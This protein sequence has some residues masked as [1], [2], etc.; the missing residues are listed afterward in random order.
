MKVDV[1]KASISDMADLRDKITAVRAAGGK[2]NIDTKD[3]TA[4]I[5]ALDEEV[6]Q[7]DSDL[8][9]LTA[10]ATGMGKKLENE[11]KITGVKGVTP[12]VVKGLLD[13]LKDASP[14]VRKMGGDMMQDLVDTIATYDDEMAEHGTTFMD[15]FRR[16]LEKAAQL[17]PVT[18]EK[19]Q[20]VINAIIA[21]YPELKP[22]AD[23][24]GAILTAGVNS[25]DPSGVLARL[26]TIAAAAVATAAQ[27]R[28][29]FGVAANAT[30]SKP[31]AGAG[32]GGMAP[33]AAELAK[34]TSAWNELNKTAI[35]GWSQ[36]TEVALGRFGDMEQGIASLG[37]NMGSQILSWRSMRAALDE[38]NIALKN[39]DDQI[40]ASEKAIK[41]LEEQQTAYSEALQKS[42]DELQKLSTMKI[43]GEGAASDKSFAL[44]QQSASLQLQILKA[45]D[46]H[47]YALVGKL[48]KQK[49]V[50]DR[51]KEEAD[52]QASITYDPQKRELEK[53]LDPLHGQEM[54]FDAIKTR[55]ID[56]TTNIIP[57]QQKQYDD[58]TGTIETQKL[59]LEG[60]KTA[61][62]EAAVKVAFYSEQVELM[63]KN[64]LSRYD[65]M[66]A[67]AKE[68][69]SVTGTGAGGG[70]TASMAGG[71]KPVTAPSAGTTTVVSPIYLDGKKITEVVTRIIG[72]NASA[73]SRS[74]GVY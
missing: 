70:V 31:G 54:S 44:Q 28:S 74:G 30:P 27:L 19:V 13:Q 32:A 24:L 66:I 20:E 15:E 6:A 73:Y 65:E 8:A 67:K 46:A 38:A 60:I 42:K 69:A 39:Y 72:S 4:N 40:T 50:V 63:A 14:E 16:G 43:A 51:Q 25:F 49:E 56:L 52:L 61:H 29:V 55:I 17:G 48:K 53:L 1:S 58:V 11:L 18:A 5:K 2:V 71:Y 3:A 41:G 37:D 47:S 68:L 21:K 36:A 12:D 7:L 9:D 64:F 23:Q 26:A 62:D 10:E 33:M 34:L 35:Y 45:E 59:A 57:A 22:V